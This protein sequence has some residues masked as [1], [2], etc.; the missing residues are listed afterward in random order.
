MKIYFD[1]S[2]SGTTCRANGEHEQPFMHYQVKLRDGRVVIVKLCKAQATNAKYGWNII[3]PY[4]LPSNE[5]VVCQCCG[6]HEDDLN[7]D[8]CC[9]RMC[10][11]CCEEQCDTCVECEEHATKEYALCS[12]CRCHECCDEL[13]VDCSDCGAHRLNGDLCSSNQRCSTCCAQ[14]CRICQDC[15]DHVEDLCSH[16]SNCAENCCDCSFCSDCDALSWCENCGMCQDHCDCVNEEEEE[17]DSNVTMSGSGYGQPWKAKDKEE[18]KLFDCDRLVG[19]EWEFNQVHSA[20]GL[21]AWKSKWNGQLAYDGSC[22]QEAV[23][24]PLAGDHMVHCLTE[25]GK[26]LKEGEA[27]I[28]DRCGVH[29]H[30]DASDIAW[31]D[32]F[33][34]LKVYAHVEPLLYMLAGQQRIN[35][36][37]CIPCGESFL[38]ALS[39]PDRKGAVLEAA[40]TERGGRTGHQYNRQKP[41]KKD[42]NRYKGLNLC[43]WLAGRKIRA[44]DT[45]VEFRL[46]RNVPWSDTERTINWT[47]VCARIVD[48]SA[49]ANDKD[50][51][52][53]PKSALRSLCKIIAPECNDYILHRLQMWRNATSFTKGTPRRILLKNGKYT[54]QLHA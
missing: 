54:M 44:K 46:H 31:N 13:C 38:N 12:S 39:K 20:T 2:G 23:T 43:P 37:Y 35:N 14:H 33:R 49:N 30:V 29:V 15:H 34:V 28:N 36:R 3:A 47:K 53:L 21:N 45:T 4:E 8:L 25:L 26:A 41:G 24:P 40:Y 18:R 7:E 10:A 9:D 27:E 48:W 17:G 50:V 51:N 16:C 1:C 19:I 52:E 5:K 11:K 6:T 32:M 42:G 22:G